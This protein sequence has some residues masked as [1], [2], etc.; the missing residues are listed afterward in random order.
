MA[1]L[2]ELSMLIVVAALL[3]Q[4]G[5]KPSEPPNDQAPAEHIDESVVKNDADQPPAKTPADD[6]TYQLKELFDGKTLTGWKATEFGGEGEV[7]VQDGVVVMEMGIMTGITWIGETDD[8]PRNNYELTLE[9]RRT[10]GI[11]FFCTTTFPV[12]DEPCSLVVGGWAG[13]VVGLSNVDHYDAS[14]NSTATFYSFEDK[15]WYKIRIRV[16]DA[17]IQA[18]IDDEQVVD[19]DRKDHQFG[20]RAEVELCQPLGICTWETAGEVRNIRIRRL[21]PSECVIR[22]DGKG[23]KGEINN[24]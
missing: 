22:K 21:R 15:Q 13:T 14:E 11:D 1:K 23:E 12:G 16:T 10:D 18:W 17:K 5:C 19:Q 6:E 7:R 2:P 8:L 3:V 24:I 9:G 4:P 20:I